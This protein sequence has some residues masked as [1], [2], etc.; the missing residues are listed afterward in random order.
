MLEEYSRAKIYDIE[1]RDTKASLEVNWNVND[2]ATNKCQ[3]LRFTFPDGSQHYIS[4]KQFLSF[5]WTIGA[6]EEQRRMVVQNIERVHWRETVLG[7]EAKKDI[8][9][10]ERINVPIKIS[11]PCSLAGEEIIGE[12]KKQ[13]IKYASGGSISSVDLGKIG[14]NI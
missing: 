9:K 10:G 7:I 6:A 14:K 8:R 3:A 13:E 11:F 5:L 12:Y 2:G 1:G 4:K